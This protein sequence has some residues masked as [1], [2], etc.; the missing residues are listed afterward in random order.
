MS[1]PAPVDSHD[2]L[3]IP[4]AALGLCGS[5]KGLHPRAR[6]KP[7]Q[8]R[9]QL[10]ERERRTRVFTHHRISFLVKKVRACN[11]SERRLPFNPVPSPQP[12]KEHKASERAGVLSHCTV[13]VDEV[14]DDT[15]ATGASL[16]W[17]QRAG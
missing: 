14:G 10:R 17:Q 8:E 16:W 11:K 12:M 4:G 15:E 9:A 5:E 1:P 7:W 13:D 6:V 3:F 2:F